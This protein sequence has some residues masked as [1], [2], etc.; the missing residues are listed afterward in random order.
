[1]W[2]PRPRPSAIAER[3]LDADRRIALAAM[4]TALQPAFAALWNLDLA[5]ADVVASS[6]DPA[7]GAIRLAWWREALEALDRSPAP[8]EPRLIAVAEQLLPRRTTGAELSQLED[9]WLPLLD[10][11]P[12]GQRAAEGLRARGRLLFGVGAQLL[13]ARA[14]EAAPL[15]ALWSLVDGARHCSDDASRDFLAHQARAEIAELPSGRSPRV[16]RPMTVLAAVAARDALS[17]RPLDPGS[18]I[19]RGAAATLHRLLGVVPRSR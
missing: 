9:A 6:S 19:R 18:G 11:F 2:S 3:A 10:P 1:M 17:A 16:L 8:A 14:A 5:F 15:G 13:G 7:L 4:P 12:W